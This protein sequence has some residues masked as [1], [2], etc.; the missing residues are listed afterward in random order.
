M[1][2]TTS[3]PS[4]VIAVAEPAFL[5]RILAE[6][7]RETYDGRPTGY[8]TTYSRLLCKAVTFNFE[9]ASSSPSCRSA[10]SARRHLP[11]L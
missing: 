10:R 4:T 1:T 7:V 9:R 2:A 3:S 11:N 5:S 8:I 6:K